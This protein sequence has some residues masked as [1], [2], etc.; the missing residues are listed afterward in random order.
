MI[1]TFYAVA[2][3]A[4][5]DTVLRS[6]FRRDI[7]DLR[8][9][10]IPGTTLLI[11]FIIWCVGLA[12][13]APALFDGLV[14]VTPDHHIL[15]AGRLTSSNIAQL[16]YLILGVA[17]VII[18]ARDP[19]TGPRILGI[20]LSLA[21]ALSMWR[22]LATELHVWFP[23]GVFDNA[24]TLTYI[25]T[26]PGGAPRFRGIFSEPSALAGSAL[27]AI[28]YGLAR[29]GQLR[30]VRRFPPLILAGVAA[31]LGAVSTSTTF[32]IAGAV[33]AVILLALSAFEFA[34]ARARVGL[35]TAI[36]GCLVVLAL[37]WLAAPAA[38]TV[39]SA[40]NGKV[41]TA[42]FSERTDANVASYNV[43][44]ETW[45]LGVGLGSGR[46]SSFIATLVSTTG[47][48]GTA[49]FVAAI[50]LI[51]YSSLSIRQARPALWVLITLLVTKAVAGPDL[52]DPTG[53]LWMTLGVLA[54]AKI[55]QDRAAHKLQHAAKPGDLPQVAHSAHRVA[56]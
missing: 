42:S 3:C 46:A 34:V 53:L 19:R 8:S 6:M 10:E 43:F 31:F 17:V 35:G 28:A 41:S 7:E 12:V 26:A 48:V 37:T 9:P 4:V 44:G 55:Q 22:Y 13:L 15:Q 40:F 45:G 36:V 18:L 24:P 30:G 5:I 1:Y 47:I 23:A 54:A 56:A 27:V 32:I 14:T 49:L 2:C 52:S 39:L 21:M 51:A 11:T 20:S 38:R 33:V 25:E 50:A 16:T 29:A